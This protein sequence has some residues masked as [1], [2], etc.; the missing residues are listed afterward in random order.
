[1]QPTF[2]SN[3]NDGWNRFRD[4]AEASLEALRSQNRERT[5]KPSIFESS[6]SKQK[7]IDLTHNDYLGL[8]SD[9][10][11][12]ERARKRASDSPLGSGASRLLGGNLQVFEDLENDFSD[13]KGCE[14]SLYFATGFSANQA[15]MVA[16]GSKQTSVFSDQLNHASLIDG[17]RLSKIPKNQKNIYPHLDLDFLEKS[18]QESKSEINI[19]VTESIFSMDGDVAPLQKLKSLADRYRGIIIVDE[20]HAVGC[21]GTEGN[22]LI[23]ALGLSHDEI[24]SVNTCGKALGMQG[25]FVCGPTWLRKIL[26]NH[27][28]SFI[29]STAPSPFI[30]AALRE[31][32]LYIRT[33]AD[34]RTK[35]QELSQLLFQGLGLSRHPGTEPVVSHIIPFLVGGD[36]ETLKLAEKIS[37]LGIKICPIRPPTVPEF[38]SRIRISLN[39][40]LSKTEVLRIIHAFD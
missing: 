12:Q 25:A 22:G 14:S 27:A 4:L 7:Q 1:M 32:I 31:S 15:L 21:Y 28:R 39:S 16:V 34:R 24:I 20:A 10:Q 19:I 40:S 23:S 6:D 26:V 8:R 29:Y 5:L 9:S 35:L 36:S 11:F 18:L 38:S 33:L 30:A 3:Q 17:L 2:P 13:F 37:D